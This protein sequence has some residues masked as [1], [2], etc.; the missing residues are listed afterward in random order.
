MVKKFLDVFSE[1]ILR[2][3]P[4]RE[5]EYTTDLVPSIEVMSKTPYWMAPVKMK[6]LKKQLE[7]LEKGY[8]RPSGLPWG[9]PVL[10][11]RKKDDSMRLCINYWWLNQ[12]MLKNKY[13]LQWSNDLFNQLKDT[14]VL[15]KIDLR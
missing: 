15:S 11:I 3:P 13:L 7:L 14:I 6:E 4:M 8:I 9:A 5:V 12:F 1:D 2:L 10:F